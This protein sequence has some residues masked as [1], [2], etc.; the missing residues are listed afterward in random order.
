MLLA[1]GCWNRK[2]DVESEEGVKRCDNG[3]KLN[4]KCPNEVNESPVT[5]AFLAVCRV[6][7]QRGPLFLLDE[8]TRHC[9]FGKLP[10]ELGQS[11]EVVDQLQRQ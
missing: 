9:Q 7:P 1:L 5:S 8:Y 6:T 4:P 3:S 10:S 2:D 11:D